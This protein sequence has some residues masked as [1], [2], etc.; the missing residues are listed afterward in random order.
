MV[1]RDF[2]GLWIHRIRFQRV[3]RMAWQFDR[4]LGLNNR[5]ARQRGRWRRHRLF[6]KLGVGL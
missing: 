5:V 2:D 6:R 3:V 4:I 1:G